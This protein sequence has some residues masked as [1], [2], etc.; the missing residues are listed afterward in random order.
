M[1]VACKKVNFIIKIL[2][3]V[4]PFL[5]KDHDISNYITAVDKHVSTATREHSKNRI[6]VFY[7][8]R[9]EML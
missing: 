8:V 5:G 6:G 9:A 2:W 3:Q 7:A 4:D 1:L